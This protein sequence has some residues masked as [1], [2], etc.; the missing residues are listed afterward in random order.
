MPA[1]ETQIKMHSLTISSKD[2]AEF[3]S[4]DM[5]GLAADP[6]LQR[7]VHLAVVVG[8]ADVAAVGVKE[9]KVLGVLPH[10]VHLGREEDAVRR[11]EQEA[12]DR[13]EEEV[14]AR[15][16]RAPRRVEGDARHH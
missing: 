13:A 11:E 2:H 14:A 4:H 12:D 8:A 10:G 6:L 7:V 15:D 3:D 16:L 1:P 9:A 5:S